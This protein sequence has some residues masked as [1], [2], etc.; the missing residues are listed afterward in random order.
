[1]AAVTA[2]E[3]LLAREEDADAVAASLAILVEHGGR[4][5]VHD[6][7]YPLCA[8]H[9]TSAEFAAGLEAARRRIA[10]LAS[11]EQ[12]ARGTSAA[13]NDAARETSSTFAMVERD[14]AAHQ[15]EERALREAEQTHT[16][17]FERWRIDPR[18][19]SD[20]DGLEAH[21]GVE[22]NSLINLERALIVLEASQSV[23]RITSVEK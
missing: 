21:V 7:H 19:L 11:G 3:A 4:V 10:S 12:D 1:M 17:F 23:F 20:P 5:G 15:A 2:T 22:R 16:G 18:F 8:A 14:V 6:E 13:A 9:R